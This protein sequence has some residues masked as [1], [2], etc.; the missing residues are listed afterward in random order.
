MKNDNERVDYL[1]LEP[2]MKE[3]K[4]KE[5]QKKRERRAKKVKTW[6]SEHKSEILLLSPV[7]VSVVT[8]TVRAITGTVKT[9]NRR[10]MLNKEKELKECYCYD[11]SL[12]H[13]WE[14]K[15]KL[16]NS[17]WVKINKRRDNG[18][19]LADILDEMNVLKR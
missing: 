10:S 7:A 15:R 13:Y 11:R 5:K 8:G 1:N 18:E 19:S 2:L 16:S 17:E 4:R 9:I 3:A 6:I 14:L 12:G